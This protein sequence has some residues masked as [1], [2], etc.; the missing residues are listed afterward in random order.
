MDRID[1]VEFVKATV[2]F[3]TIGES[4]AEVAFVG[5][6]NVGK[7]S[8]L[9]AVCGQKRLAH[10]SK[11]PGKTRTIN[12]FNV[13]HYHWLIDLPGYGYATGSSK[14]LAKWSGMI[15]GY[16]SVRRNLKMVYL[17]VDAKVGP[18]KLDK[19]M[20]EWLITNS[21]PYFIVANKIDKLKQKDIETQR[22]MISGE[23]GV[24]PEDV[25][26]VSAEKK[27]GIPKLVMSIVE[28]LGL[29]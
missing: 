22:T 29:A 27:T 9:N 20:T 2:D 4:V 5:R 12:V 19:Q 21:V 18:T 13:A 14:E 15:E 8:V 3:N 1:S 10:V 25:F 23:L 24:V 11:I 6:S 28:Q 26:W 7:S 17:I 16:L